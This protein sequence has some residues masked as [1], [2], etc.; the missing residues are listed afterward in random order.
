MLT[1]RDYME[2]ATFL[3][4]QD[5]SKQ[6]SLS[7]HQTTELPHREKIEKNAKIVTHNKKPSLVL[8]FTPV[9]ILIV[10]IPLFGLS[11]SLL[12]AALVFEVVNGFHD[13]SNVVAPLVRSHTLSY[14]SA[15]LW[16]S[17]CTALPV[18]MIGIASAKIAHAIG[19]SLFLEG[20]LTQAVMFSGVVAAFSWGLTTWRYG[21]PS[22]S[23]HSLMGGIAGASMMT[24]YMSNLP[25]VGHLLTTGWIILI[26]SMVFVPFITGFFAYIISKIA[27]YYE[28]KVSSVPATHLVSNDNTYKHDTVHGGYIH[29][30]YTLIKH[31]F[32]ELFS[33]FKNVKKWPMLAASGVLSF[34]H[35]RNDGQK[36]MPMVA[37]VIYSDPTRISVFVQLLCYSAI[38]LGTLMGG[39][40]IMK[41]LNA[42][43]H[44]HKPSGGVIS[45]FVTSGVVGFATE[46]GVGVSTTQTTA[47]AIMG[48]SYARTKEIVQMMSTWIMTP[49][50]SG[51]LAALIVFIVHKI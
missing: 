36:A 41:K 3:A 13:V 35:S 38:T 19:S 31:D 26:A 34:A 32:S 6:A 5:A 4:P 40:I 24:A 25:I 17:I 23:S 29:K 50:S 18:L 46:L 22:S 7:S 51:I 39:S 10:M 14:R 45:M 42:M 37:G 33:A 48:T 15:V 20:T 27:V 9:I 2:E 28:S 47:S 43:G 30:Y 12:I 21:L 11:P 16:S 49:I 1:Q 44:N 8:V